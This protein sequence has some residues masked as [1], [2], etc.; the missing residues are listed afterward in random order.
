MGDD[1]RGGREAVRW[2]A[3]VPIGTNPL[4]LA[5]VLKLLCALWCLVVPSVVLLQFLF[6]G[7]LSGAQA[8]AAVGLANRFVLL[9]GSVFFVAAFLFLQNRYVVLCRLDDEGAYCESMRRGW[10]APAESLHWRSFGVKAFPEPRT[11]TR[12]TVPWADV[13]ALEPVSGM[14][15]ILLKKGRATLLRLYCPDDALFE[16]ALEFA[17]ARIGGH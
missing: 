3:G 12:K 7:S 5:D 10:G 17:R 8:G 16:Q 11:S 15:T 1:P 6:A 13:D 9:T 4:I 2:Y 14:R